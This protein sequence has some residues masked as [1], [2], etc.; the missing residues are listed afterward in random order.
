[1]AAAPEPEKKVEAPKEPPKEATVI[2]NL[3]LRKPTTML[4]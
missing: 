4:F 3:S 2:V 1:M